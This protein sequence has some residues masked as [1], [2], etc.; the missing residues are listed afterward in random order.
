MTKHIGLVRVNRY[1]LQQAGHGLRVDRQDVLFPV[2]GVTYT[3]HGNWEPHSQ[4][5]LE[6]QRQG[7]SLRMSRCNI[8]LLSRPIE[9]SEHKN[10]VAV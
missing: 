8:H 5:V 1:I 7:V 2:L 4:S 6:S 10:R 9:G 3:V